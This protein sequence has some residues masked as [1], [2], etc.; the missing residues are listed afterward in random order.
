MSPQENDVFRGFDPQNA[1]S[2]RQFVRALEYMLDD[3]F[4]LNYPA[5]R[6]LGSTAEERG[7]RRASLQATV[8]RMRTDATF[9]DA[10]QGLIAGYYHDDCTLLAAAAA[11]AMNEMNEAGQAA[12]SHVAE[13]NNLVIFCLCIRIVQN[14]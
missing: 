10:V 14:I 9:S 12:G 4:Q 13:V 11:L 8:A 1:L 3:G 6:D 5:L 7:D 2:L